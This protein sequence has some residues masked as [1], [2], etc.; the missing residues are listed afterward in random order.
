MEFVKI[1]ISFS[2]GKAQEAIGLGD[3]NNSTRHIRQFPATDN[4]S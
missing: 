2:I 1:F 3:L 4:N